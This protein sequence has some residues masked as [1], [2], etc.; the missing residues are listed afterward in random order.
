MNIQAVQKQRNMLN[1]II[2]IQAAE[3]ILGGH[4]T[5]QNHPVSSTNKLQEII[6]GEELYLV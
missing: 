2:G 6:D 5:G 1:D 4:S 3:S